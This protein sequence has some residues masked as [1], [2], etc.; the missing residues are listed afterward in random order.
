MKLIAIDLDGT[1]LNSK[2]EI[3][4][5]NLKAIKMADSCGIKI[6]I[7]TGRSIF[8]AVEIIESLNIDAFLLALNGAVVAE[9][10]KT[11]PLKI[12]RK[13]LLEKEKISD[14]LK[15]A[16]QKE[17]TFIAS[18]EFGSD[19]VEFKSTQEL[20]QE[21]YEERPDLNKVSLDE[22]ILNISKNKKEYLKLAFTDSNT[23]NLLDL[24]QTL[25]KENIATI[26]SDHHYIEH[27]P[28][29]INKGTSLAYL[30]DLIGISLNDVVAIGDQEND[31]EMLTIS[32]LGVAMGNANEK[33]KKQANLVTETNDKNGVALVIEKVIDTKSSIST[34]KN[35]DS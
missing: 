25:K 32:G 17:I 5:A 13:S 23:Q 15:L 24:Q 28:E 9:K 3:S 21:F 22:M 14:S 35:K 30:T 2:N 4:E 1:L 29:G 7:A 26:F 20:V 11:S 33:I 18:G 10:K 31:L 16:R 8:S 27:L 12:I 6:V 34:Q 19:R